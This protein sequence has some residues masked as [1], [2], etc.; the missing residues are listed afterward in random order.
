MVLNDAQVYYS[1][2]NA[3]L[4][5]SNPLDLSGNGRTGTNNGCETGSTGRINEGFDFVASN[6]DY[7]VAEYN[8]PLNN[9]S[10]SIWANPDTLASD[11]GFWTTY[12]PS[13]SSGIALIDDVSHGINIQSYV[14]GG[15]RHYITTSQK[16]TVGAWSHIV[17]T[18]SSGGVCKLY[19]NGSLLGSDTDTITSHNHR[20]YI[21]VFNSAEIDG[22]MDE[23]GIW[24]R[25]LSST[26]V[27]ELYNAGV[28]FNP[29]TSTGYANKVNGVSG[30]SEVY[31]RAGADISKVNG[32]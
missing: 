5:G 12:N 15:L 11:Y 24:S 29:Y 23:I 19:Y 30:V 27:S 10:I 17:V 3:N 18:M 20:P 31:D 28:G 21:G 8:L 32:V 4:S 25:E 14:S 26:E 9:F 1:L 6:A 13:S 2:D 16:L 22:K 7:L